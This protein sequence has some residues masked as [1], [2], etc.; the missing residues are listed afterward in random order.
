MHPRPGGLSSPG[1]ALPHAALCPSAVSSCLQ[2]PVWLPQL[3]LGPC[4]PEGPT[5]RQRVWVIGGAGPATLPLLCL[6]GWGVPRPREP[7]MLGRVQSRPHAAR[8]NIVCWITRYAWALGVP[9]QRGPEVSST[10]PLSKP[11]GRRRKGCSQKTDRDGWR[12]AARLPTHPEHVP[13][14]NLRSQ[15]YRPVP[16]GEMGA[17]PGPHCQEGSGPD[18]LRTQVTGPGPLPS[19]VHVVA[20]AGQWEEALPLTPTG[21]RPA[22]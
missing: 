16:D 22:D 20:S 19:C 9:E 3:A 17:Q 2:P 15:V 7:R 5:L 6:G 10:G 14:S 1:P 18:S 13:I 8:R 11:R 12:A 21:W 4:L